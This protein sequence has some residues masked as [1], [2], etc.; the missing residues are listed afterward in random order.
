MGGSPPAM[1]LGDGEGRTDLSLALLEAD[2]SHDQPEN[3]QD[4]DQ[5]D[6][7]DEKIR[8]GRG[9]VRDVRCSHVHGNGRDRY[10]DQKH[11]G[12]DF[13]EVLQGNTTF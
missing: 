4:D 11:H 6:Q 9:D 1:S 7:I 8:D 2:H 5:G 10:H 3:G 12:Y 13:A